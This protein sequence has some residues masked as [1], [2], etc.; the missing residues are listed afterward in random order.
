MIGALQKLGPGTTAHVHFGVSVANLGDFSDAC[1]SRY[2]LTD[3]IEEEW[4][5]L[6]RDL[7]AARPGRRR[8]AGRG[9]DRTGACRLLTCAPLGREPA[10]ALPLAALQHRARD[11]ESRQ[12][13]QRLRHGHRV[14][15][16]RAEQHRCEF[17]ACQPDFIGQFARAH[18]QAKGSPFD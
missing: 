3:M 16:M 18:G 14:V 4:K 13:R 10:A 7:A 9:Q 5:V 11:V 6:R 2:V 12:P 17:A 8:D 15:Q 1:G